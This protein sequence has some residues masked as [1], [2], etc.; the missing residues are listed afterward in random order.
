MANCIFM[1]KSEFNILWLPM[2]YNYVVKS[3]LLLSLLY[4]SPT[5]LDAV[6][7]GHLYAIMT[8]ELPNTGLHQV[9][10]KYP[11]LL[12]YCQ[13]IDNQFFKAAH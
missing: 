5:E 7:F 2:A 3:D 10:M 6:L 8:I 9:V 4:C 13:R 1:G 11:N 12:Q